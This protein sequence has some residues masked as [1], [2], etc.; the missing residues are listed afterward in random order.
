[1]SNVTEELLGKALRVRWEGGIRSEAYA[2]LA[3]EEKA[4]GLDGQTYIEAFARA[5]AMDEAAWRLAD[6]FHASNRTM[7]VSA[8]DLESAHPGFAREDYNQSFARNL[9][10]ANK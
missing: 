3:L 2:A 7:H 10:L 8:A 1:M 9:A 5:S 4:P 6:A